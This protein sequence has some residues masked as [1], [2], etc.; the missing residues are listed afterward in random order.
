MGKLKAVITQNIDGLHQA[1]CK[2][3]TCYRLH[4]SVHKK[5]LSGLWKILRFDQVYEMEGIPR[6]QCGGIIQTRCCVRRGRIES[7]NH[8]T[9]SGGNC[10]G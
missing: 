9:F 1:V 2:L 3:K 10:Q 7:E 5:S 4:G 8:T 6:C